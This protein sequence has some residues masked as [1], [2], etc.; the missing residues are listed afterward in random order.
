MLLSSSDSKK[1][2]PHDLNL[3]NEPDLAVY[4]EA[5]PFSPAD[6]YMILDNLNEFFYTYDL[7]TCITFINKKA[8]EAM[9]Y[10]SAEITGQ[11]LLK[12]VV[13][14]YRT[15]VEQHI[16]NRVELGMKDS[17]ELEI[18]TRNGSRRLIHVNCTPIKQGERVTGGMVLAQ[19][20][21]ESRSMES[22][23][24]YQLEFERLIASISGRL[25]NINNNAIDREIE[26]ALER[27]AKFMGADRSYIFLRSEDG[28]SISATHEWCAP[29]IKEFKSDFQNF[30]TADYACTLE[31]LTKNEYVY[32]PSV[33]QLPTK[34]RKELHMLYKYNLHCFLA[35]PLFFNQHYVGLM[36]FTS[37]EM[38]ET[39]NKQDVE[40]LKIA[41][42]TIVNALQH[43]R[44]KNKIRSGLSLFN[45]L[46]E[47]IVLLDP[48][49]RLLWCNQAFTN[50]TGYLKIEI[51]NHYHISLDFL[52]AA[53]KEIHKA[54]IEQVKKAGKWQGQIKVLRKNGEE[55]IA[56]VS[57]SV[58]KNADA[59]QYYFVIF[60]DATEQ[61][62]LK[63]ERAQL[64]KQTLV[65]Q[66]LA[67]LST[68][69]A[70][71]VH[72]IAQPLNTIKILV[73][74]MLYWHQ[75]GKPLETAEMLK[76][77]N[78]ISLETERINDI[79]KYIR[80][81]ASFNEDRLTTCNLNR[82]VLQ[83]LNLVGRQL[84]DHNIRVEL[85]LK[86]D[87][88]EVCG[89]PSRMEEI[90]INLLVNAMHALD[91]SDRKDKMIQCIT[92]TVDEKVVLEVCD[93]ATGIDS[94]I[95]ECIFEPFVTQKN[96]EH[97]MGLGLS[98]V[99]TIISSL[100]GKVTAYNNKMGGA[101]FRIELPGVNR[102]E[103]Q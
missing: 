11:P 95:I 36:G 9:G 79:M 88:A 16:K 40:L 33:D 32:S 35:V 96:S 97:G 92:F 93:N 103:E 67:S 13:P 1:L 101:T 24:R 84:E 91:Q 56:L 12:F 14:E 61:I 73:D 52:P 27:I 41:G 64:K 55:F 94:D 45:R 54:I 57:I 71:I 38:R 37:V 7:N 44:A 28:K 81:Y 98:I 34:V 99:H 17:Y 53:N 102:R 30:R 22:I 51:K 2:Y 69:S 62:K 86:G 85:S 65:A 48:K 78:D 18:V 5:M 25:V 77:L 58:I 87:L 20:V 72:E 29:G 60:M 8:Q 74:G 66:R 76:K 83:S 80:S 50:I 75:A 100:Q 10:T 47:G 68:L 89:N 15:M 23:L 49:G 21:T 82:A 42:Q 63:Q 6:L 70:G 4:S 46:K 3:I 31:L 39:W 26:E 19:D 59:I 43:R 90:I